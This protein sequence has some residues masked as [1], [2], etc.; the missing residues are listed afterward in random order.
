MM[1]AIEE[2]NHSTEILPNVTLGYLIYDVC[3]TMHTTLDATLN[4]LQEMIDSDAD[5]NCKPIAVIGPS[6]SG[7]SRAVAQFLG[8]FYIPQVIFLGNE[9][10]YLLEVIVFNLISVTI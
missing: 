9:D 1:F 6:Q 10:V 2:I 4:F 7:M 3:R 5:F 8:L